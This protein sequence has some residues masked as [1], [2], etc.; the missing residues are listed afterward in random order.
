[1]ES[2]PTKISKNNNISQCVSSEMK[3]KA[4]SSRINSPVLKN[5]NV[6][7]PSCASPLEM[8]TQLILNPL[9]ILYIVIQ[10]G[11]LKDVEGY[12]NERAL[13]TK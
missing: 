1:M 3:I 11:F 2:R 7:K 9:I 12:Y 8:M 5:Q 6:K 4:Y 13:R 10:Y